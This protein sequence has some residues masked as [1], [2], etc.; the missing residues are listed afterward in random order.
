MPISSQA[1]APAYG[2]TLLPGGGGGG[3]VGVG[4]GVV[5]CGGGLVGCGGGLVG[6]GGGLVGCGGGLVGCGGG[7]V[8]CGGGLVGCGGG[9]V[10]VGVGCGLSLGPLQM[11]LTEVRDVRWICMPRP[12]QAISALSPL[13]KLTLYDCAQTETAAINTTAS[14]T[15]TT[16]IRDFD[17]T[18][19]SFS[20]SAPGMGRRSLTGGCLF[21]LCSILVHLPAAYLKPQAADYFFTRLG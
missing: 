8:G 7:L 4:G 3:E 18:R 16:T 15:P 9:L 17:F 1:G 19:C 12:S 5:G 14:R 20:L 10:N 2:W 21:I 13:S 6:C 11:T